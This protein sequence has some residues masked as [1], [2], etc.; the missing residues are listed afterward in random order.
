MMLAVGPQLCLPL[1]VSGR[2]VE[3]ASESCAGGQEGLGH[4]VGSSRKRGDVDVALASGEGKRKL[5]NWCG[6]Q[7]SAHRALTGATP[8]PNP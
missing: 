6:A 4:C 7:L 3:V 1:L 2:D 8:I 5:I